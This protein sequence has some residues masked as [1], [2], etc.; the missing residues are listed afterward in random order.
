MTPKKIILCCIATLS[1][2]C[3]IYTIAFV[4]YR[5]SIDEKF[6]CQHYIAHGGGAIDGHPTT[7]SLEAITKTIDDSVK[8]IELDFQITSDSFLVAAHDWGSFAQMSGIKVSADNPPSYEVFKSARLFNKYTPLT[9]EMIDSIFQH[10][11]DLFLVT[12]KTDDIRLLLKYL[13]KLKGR[14]FIECFSK[15]S[16]EKCVES[17][18]CTPMH[19]YLNLCF[20]DL[21]ATA[22]NSHRYKYL[23]FIPSAFALFPQGIMNK[24]TADSLFKADERVKFIYVDE[25]DK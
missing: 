24:S 21:N 8:F 5:N 2:I 23:R 14:L 11:T 17:K 20:G 13:P 18:S 3:G 1:V 19:S 6:P 9:C 22:V 15:N 25:F 4:H 10:H 7:N 12:D 16:F